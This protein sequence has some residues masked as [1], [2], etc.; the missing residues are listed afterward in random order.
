MGRRA[1]SRLGP[2]LVGICLLARSLMPFPWTVSW[3]VPSLVSRQVALV[4]LLPEGQGEMLE[5]RELPP[6]PRPCALPGPWPSG[7]PAWA[8]QGSQGN[9]GSSGSEQQQLGPMNG[10][11]GSGLVLRRRLHGPWTADAVVR[12]WM[13]GEGGIEGNKMVVRRGILQLRAEG[14]RPS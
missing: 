13:W 9:K 3:A 2:A 7:A 4:L 14:Q 6:S 8:P 1:G 5:A 10:G 11:G 12:D